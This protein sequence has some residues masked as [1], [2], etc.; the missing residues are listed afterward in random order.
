VPAAAAAADGARTEW[1]PQETHLA[2]FL[3]GIKHSRSSATR[4]FTS[5]C[6]APREF[7]GSIAASLQAT[8]EKRRSA[9]RGLVASLE[10]NKAAKVARLKEQIDINVTHHTCPRIFT[11]PEVQEMNRREIERAHKRGESGADII[12]FELTKSG[13]LKH[14][15]CYPRC[16]QYLQCFASTTDRLNPKLRHGLM[17]HLKFNSPA[18]NLVPG[19]HLAAA[20]FARGGASWED[21][22]TRM[23]GEYKFSRAYETLADREEQL[24]SMWQQYNGLQYFK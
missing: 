16:P 22:L 21:F 5:E 19:I 20:R 17:N 8:L 9:L 13:L 14:H 2:L 11:A 10:H 12:P 6:R 18:H 15:C 23:N 3:F 24:R 7:I 4:S 1:T